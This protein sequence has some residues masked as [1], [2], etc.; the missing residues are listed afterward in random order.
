MKYIL[1][2]VISLITSILVF[3]FL[4]N[5]RFGDV[6]LQ[7]N[8]NQKKVELVNEKPLVDLENF[9]LKDL[10]NELIWISENVKSSVVSIE[11]SKDFIVYDGRT[12]TWL[13]EQ[14]I[15]WWSGIIV[16]DNGYIL[17]N[18]H[19]VEDED[20]SYTVIF[21]DGQ[22]AE[23]NQVRMDKALDIAIIKIQSNAVWERSVANI[24]PFWDAIQIGQF[25][26]AIWNA[27]AEFQNS[28]TFWVVSGKNRKLTI[29]SDNLYA[30]LLQTDTSISEWNSGWPLFDLDG[31]VIGIN[32]AVSAYGENIGFAI[33][34][35]Q[36]FVTATLSSIQKYD[37]LVRPFVWV[38]YIDLNRDV[39]LELETEIYNGIYI[40]EIVPDSPA[41][42][43][44][45]EV[46]DI[47]TH[48][49]TV[50]IDATNTFLYQLFT[51]SPGDTIEVTY[52]RG[53]VSNTTEMVLSTQ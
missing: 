37:D 20:A 6:K 38:R 42:R 29:D 47:I 39:A 34:I 33:P 19:V 35:T 25:A 50:A 5:T 2:I 41:D 53:W 31:Q 32:T 28:V 40:A 23:T 15:W 45:F 43:A 12:A 1:T 10:E 49:D 44:R 11:V 22:R 30:W 52:M 24:I 21:S 48:I 51:H 4:R 9:G 8:T 13:I 14:E 3:Q 46:D 16:S 17:T 18:K 26:I 7:A 27:L 36:E